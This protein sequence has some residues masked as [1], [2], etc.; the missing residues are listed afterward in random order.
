MMDYVIR[1]VSLLN[2]HIADGVGSVLGDAFGGG[3]IPISTIIRNTNTN[4]GLPSVYLAA[5]IDNEVIGFNAFISHE[6]I[7]SNQKISCYQSC[8]TATSSKHR[9]KKIFQNLILSAHEILR[10]RGVAFIFG[11]PNDSS[12]PL[13]TKKLGYRKIPSLKW[14]QL[15]FPV[16]RGRWYN[17]NPN[18]ITDLKQDAILQNDRQLIELKR[19]EFGNR[20]IE[21]D[22]EGSLGWGV[23]R[24]SVR[25]GVPV[26][27]LDL[28][29]F[30]LVDSLHLP[31][32]M[33]LLRRK[34]GVIAYTQ[35]VTVDGNSFNGL[36]HR[37]EP[38]NSNCLIIYD[39]NL[40]TEIGVRFNFLTGIRDVFK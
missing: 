28:G 8:W 19:Q 24:V 25:K 38:S 14:Q 26:P 27:Y 10:D 16:V 17:A 37:V 2:E 1:E 18:L 35:L 30:D 29:G 12:Y 34:T 33:S 11:F 13:F 31:E 9:G 6:L 20:L 39:L 21:V 5:M 23:R 36:M 3:S 4:S 22:F 32:L 7:F 40:D 15:N